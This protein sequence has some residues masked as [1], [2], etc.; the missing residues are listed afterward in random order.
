[1]FSR[2]FPNHHRF[3][4]FYYLN[5]LYPLR[6]FNFLINKYSYFFLMFHGFQNLTTF[7]ILGTPCKLKVFIH[8]LT[9]LVPFHSASNTYLLSCNSR[10]IIFVAKLI[11]ISPFSLIFG[12]HNSIS[13]REG[14]ERMRRRNSL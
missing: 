9:C 8:K 10:D 2:C 6:Q 3:N 11:V 7:W 14:K 5:T 13:K 4:S 12:Q 1:M